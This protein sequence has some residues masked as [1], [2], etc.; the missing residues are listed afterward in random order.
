MTLKA[1]KREKRNIPG[2]FFSNRFF[3]FVNE[4]L[5]L[6]LVKSKSNHMRRKSKVKV[7]VS[8]ASA[9]VAYIKPFVEK[10]LKLG[11][12]LKTEEIAFTSEESYGCMSFNSTLECVSKAKIHQ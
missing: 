1:I 6:N 5:L 7:F 8:H 10:V 11:L 2:L 12:E 9:D 4:S 3:V